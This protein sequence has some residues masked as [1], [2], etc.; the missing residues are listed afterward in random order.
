MSE[1]T[2]ASEEIGQA[3]QTNAPSAGEVEGAVLTGWC[4][5]AE[6]MAPDGDRWLSK[7]HPPH[8]TTWQANGMHH[9]AM[10]GFWPEMEDE[11]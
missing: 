1:Y 2:L 7:M 4:V 10:H 9:E 8:V 3:I 6:W 11:D 5:V